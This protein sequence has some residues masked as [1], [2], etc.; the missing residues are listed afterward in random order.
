MTHI[1]DQADTNLKL[2]SRR[3]STDSPWLWFLITGGSVLVHLCFIYWVGA[4]TLQ[5]RLR[6]VS[7]A[8]TPVDFVELPAS[9]PAASE[10]V[11]L[12]APKPLA[13]S[14]SSQPSAKA[15]KAT[16]PVQPAANSNQIQLGAVPATPPSKA[17]TREKSEAV[18]SA[19]PSAK[20]QAVATT[21]TPANTVRPTPTAA[22]S[23]SPA[24]VDPSA[25]P[26]PASDAILPQTTSSPSPFPLIVTEAIDIPV[27][28]VSGSLPLPQEEENSLSAIVTNRVTI[29]SHLT[30]SLTTASVPLEDPIELDEAARPKNIV[31]RFSSN[32]TVSPCNVTP[33]AVQFLGK[34]VEMQVV[35]NETGQ[36]IDTVTHESS[37]SSDYDDLATCLV[38]NWSFE[39]AIARGEPVVN[40][41]LI[42]RITIDRS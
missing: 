29:P 2:K 9:E 24:A 17:P 6:S 35:T 38:E 31:Q 34:T 7:E 39:P 30:A 32:P 16:P 11:E 19:A 5:A 27:P 36:V 26:L 13:V 8:V 42:V 40:D 28:D 37:Q 18:P 14:T 10:S 33:E 15:A 22:S 1:N 3:R 23:P 12:I 21:P 4:S 20:P 41:G 25:S